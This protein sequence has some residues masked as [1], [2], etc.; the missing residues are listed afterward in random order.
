[1]MDP[2]TALGLVG[3]LIGSFGLFA[4]V[5]AGSLAARRA[6]QVRFQKGLLEPLRNS[7]HHVERE[8]RINQRHLD[9]QKKAVGILWE[10]ATRIQRLTLEYYEMLCALSQQYSDPTPLPPRPSLRDLP[11]ELA[12]L[13]EHPRSA[14]QGDE[15]S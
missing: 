6:R 13:K 14:H 8:L 7:L 3:W 9:E 5:G 10:E 1:M 2:W 4:A 15:A 11:H 12:F